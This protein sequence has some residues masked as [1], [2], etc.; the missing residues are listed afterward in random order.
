VHP[1]HPGKEGVPDI[2]R[3]TS[4]G[5]GRNTCADTDLEWL[6]SPGKFRR[7]PFRVGRIAVLDLLGC[8]SKS[9]RDWL[10]EPRNTRRTP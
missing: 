9:N 1:R 5:L 8:R 10:A 3:R 6:H 7:S 4:D 2:R